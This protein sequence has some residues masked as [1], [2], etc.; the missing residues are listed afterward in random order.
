MFSTSMAYLD[1]RIVACPLNEVNNV[2]VPQLRFYTISCHFYFCKDFGL[3]M[4]A[5]L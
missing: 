2:L 5:I 1:D 3:P 4:D